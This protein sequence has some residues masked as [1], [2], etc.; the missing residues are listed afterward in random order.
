MNTL[1]DLLGLVL[2]NTGPGLL[3]IRE[4]ITVKQLDKTMDITGKQWA[5]QDQILMFLLLQLSENLV[6][7]LLDIL[8]KLRPQLGVLHLTEHLQHLLRLAGTDH[9]LTGPVR[10]VLLKQFPDLVPVLVLLVI[11]LPL[12]FYFIVFKTVFQVLVLVDLVAFGVFQLKREI[13]Q[14]PQELR[15]IHRLLLSLHKLFGQVDN[16]SQVAN[17]V[18]VNVPH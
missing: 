1:Y 2:E 15:E 16:Q 5:I 3:D 6:F 7:G 4:G 14:N 17:S 12:K 13:S 10:E 9:D 11:Y 8:Q 18:F